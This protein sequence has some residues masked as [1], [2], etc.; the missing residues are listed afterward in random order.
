MT[1]QNTRNSSA[2]VPERR[3]LD[4]FARVLPGEVRCQFTSP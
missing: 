4:T 1:T 3:A 2:E